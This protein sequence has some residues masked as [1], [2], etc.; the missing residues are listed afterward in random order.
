[1]GRPYS[2]YHRNIASK[3][4]AL[5]ESMVGNHWFVDGN[6]RTAL[7]MVELLVRRSGYHIEVAETERLDDLVVTV[8]AG[9]MD[10]GAIVDWFKSRIRKMP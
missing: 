4:A 2:G 3:A 7:L 10:F 1:M 6:K 9:Q 5:L 8:A